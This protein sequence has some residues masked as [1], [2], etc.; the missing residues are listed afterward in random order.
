MKHICYVGKGS[1][2]LTNLAM[3]R[4]S[5]I[6]RGVTHKRP[7]FECVFPGDTIYFVKERDTT[8]L[9]AIVESVI[10]L[11]KPKVHELIELLETHKEAL[12]LEKAMRKKLGKYDYFV[13]LELGTVH[14]VGS[15][16]ISEIIYEETG[17]W[18]IA[19]EH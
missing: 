7:P 1:Q 12:S 11:T 13:L 16:E 17:F 8:Y 14:P 15:P 18:V 6:I 3:G 4:T 19:S 2:D 10:N 5:M 9:S